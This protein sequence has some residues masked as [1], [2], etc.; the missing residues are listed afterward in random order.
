MRAAGFRPAGVDYITKPLNAAIVRA[1]VRTHLA[2]YDQNRALEEMVRERT[3][4]LMH[5]QDVTIVGFSTLAEYRSQETGWHILA[6][7]QQY[8]GLLARYPTRRTRASFTFSRR[9]TSNC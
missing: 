3:R 4:E 9:K 6:T 8:V 2:L 5:T 1:R 7:S